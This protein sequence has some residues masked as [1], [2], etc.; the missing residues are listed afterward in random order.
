[1]L[2]PF[3]VLL[4]LSSPLAAQDYTAF[5]TPS[6]N[7]HC[8]IW[9][10]PDAELRCDM[11]DLTPSYHTAPPDCELDWG[12]SFAVGPRSQ[13]GMLACVGDTV[14]NEGAAK[15]DYGSTLSAQGFSCTS[16]KTGLSCQ[17]AAGHGFALSKARQRLF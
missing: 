4:C 16:E 3:A 10:G 15:L 6:G 17:N 14:I 11:R 8:V 13:Q 2:K 1:M 5:Q 7:I 12:F 9:G